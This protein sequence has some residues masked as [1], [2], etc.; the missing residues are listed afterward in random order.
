MKGEMSSKESNFNER[1]F[2]EI[3]CAANQSNHNASLKPFPASFFNSFTLFKLVKIRSHVLRLMANTQT[4][5]L[6]QLNSIGQF[7]GVPMTNATKVF[8]MLWRFFP[9]L[10][11]Q[12]CNRCFMELFS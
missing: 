4:N 2:N 10:D 8:P 3:F 9:V 7:L 1:L 11:P 12:V 5:N 6:N